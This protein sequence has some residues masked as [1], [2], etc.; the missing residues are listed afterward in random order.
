MILLRR[1]GIER[2]LTSGA[3]QRSE[4]VWA[5]GKNGEVSYG[6][7]GVDGR[8]KWRAGTRETE[9]GLDG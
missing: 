6:Q 8:S 7:K 5:C 3:D 9:V 4:M 1:A 2:E